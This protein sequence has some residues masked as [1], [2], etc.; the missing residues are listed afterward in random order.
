MVGADRYAAGFLAEQQGLGDL[1]ILDDGFQHRRLF[2]DVDLVTIDPVEWIAGER[3]F[4]YGRWGTK[5]A[6]VRAHA[7]IVQESQ[8][9]LAEL[10]IP[11]FAIRTVLDGIYKGSEPVPV[12]TL[13]NRAITAFAG[14]AKPD[15][16]FNALES[17][18]I[19]LTR[20][21]R[22]PDHHTYS[23]RD[24]NNLPGEVHITTEK[25]AVR[26]EGLGEFLHLRISVAVLEIDRLLGLIRSRLKR[27]PLLGCSSG[28]CQETVRASGAKVGTRA[29]TSS[30]Q[31]RTT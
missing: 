13:K 18:G 1:F 29:L 26:L 10:P 21:V 7:A 14:I 4:P 30:N 31:L 25:D 2:R 24:L 27:R 12:Q 15:R 9:P 20:R 19:S 11:A 17:T 23:E 5:E 28:F 16:F 6:L 3:L 8:A 22:F